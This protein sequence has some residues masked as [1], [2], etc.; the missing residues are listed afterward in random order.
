MTDTTTA[1]PLDLAGATTRSDWFAANRNAV[2]TITGYGL[3]AAAINSAEDVPALLAEIKWLRDGVGKI[4]DAAV[5]SMVD[6]GNRR[7]R[8]AQEAASGIACMAE[9][10]L[11]GGAA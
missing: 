9:D 6:A 7:Q 5:G 10:L 1:K 2:D 3:A 11:T 4:F 8:E